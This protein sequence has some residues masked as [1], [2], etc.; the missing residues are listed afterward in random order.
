MKPGCEPRYSAVCQ[1]GAG[2]YCD[3]DV[4]ECVSSPCQNN[5]TCTDST[6]VASL[7]T[8]TYSCACA[9]GFVNGMCLGETW[10]QDIP[11]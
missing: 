6:T 11:S 2:G 5:A 10:P 3:I 9:A 8:D 1:R 4:D 7:G